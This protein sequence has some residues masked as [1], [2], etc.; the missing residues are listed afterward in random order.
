VWGKE[1]LPGIEILVV[2]RRL[3]ETEDRLLVC[4][5]LRRAFGQRSGPEREEGSRRCEK[6][7]HCSS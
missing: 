6:A 5:D 4:L 2:K 7:R 3:V 1:L